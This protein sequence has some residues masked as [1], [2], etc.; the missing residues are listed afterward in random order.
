[1]MEVER[2]TFVGLSTPV[3]LGFPED[4]SKL[5]K[6]EKR[7]RDLAVI[8]DDAVEPPAIVRFCGVEMS[9]KEGGTT[10]TA[11]LTS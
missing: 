7:P 6:P 11:N 9:S 10:N 4:P 1:M 3:I 5:T 8:L 2:K